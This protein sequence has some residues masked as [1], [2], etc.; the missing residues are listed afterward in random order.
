MELKNQLRQKHIAFIN[1][2]TSLGQKSY[3]NASESARIA[4]YSA[5]SAGSAGK[6]LLNRERIRQEIDRITAEQNA[7]A[8]A[9]QDITREKYLSM[10]IEAYE[11]V[12]PKH[13]NGPRYAEIIGK[14]KSFFGETPSNNF[15]IYNSSDPEVKQSVEAK[16]AHFSRQLARRQSSKTA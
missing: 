7:V 4:G 2:Y 3:Q 8:A 10:M 12:G 11:T 14:T 1:A 15:L 13:S 5:E 16:L 9:R 6:K